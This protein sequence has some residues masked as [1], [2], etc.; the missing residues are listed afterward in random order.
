MNKAIINITEYSEKD[1]DISFS[2]GT[3]LRVSLIDMPISSE[4]SFQLEDYLIN[5]RL[6]RRQAVEL[7]SAIMAKRD[8]LK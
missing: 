6:Q 2:D 1:C 8:R 7:L 4:L 3:E 5:L